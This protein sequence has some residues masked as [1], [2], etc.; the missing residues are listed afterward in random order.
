MSFYIEMALAAVVAVTK[1]VARSGKS[2]IMS[3]HHGNVFSFMYNNAPTLR[4]FVLTKWRQLDDA[5]AI[6]MLARRCARAAS[7]GEVE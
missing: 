5:L 7:A 4:V 2:S 1:A 6:I 3:R